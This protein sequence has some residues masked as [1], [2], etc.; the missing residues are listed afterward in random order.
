MQKILL[1]D[2]NSTLR[3]YL[4]KSLRDAGYEVIEAG[5]AAQSLA[6]IGEM[7]DLDHDIALIV[8]DLD[9]PVGTG[10]DLIDALRSARWDVPVLV[11]TGSAWS[12]RGRQIR[13]MGVP[14]MEKPFGQAQFVG[15]CQEA[16]AR[17][18]NP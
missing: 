6:K 11:I 8:T 4:A 3:S 13:A 17:R 18:K 14:V 5:D 16:M 10:G 9:M 7:G 2:D 15:A 12:S 1:A